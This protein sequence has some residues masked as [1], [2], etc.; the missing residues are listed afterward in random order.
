LQPL[1]EPTQTYNL[2][3][4][5]DTHTFFANGKVVHNSFNK[6]S[7]GVG[8]DAGLSCPAGQE[9]IPE[10]GGACGV[11][12]KNV[13]TCPSGQSRVNGVCVETKYEAAAENCVDRCG[14]DAACKSNCNAKYSVTA[15]SAQGSLTDAQYRQ[16]T[17]SCVH[18]I[19]ISANRCLPAPG[20]TNGTL[21]L[22]TG[23]GCSVSSQCDSGICSNAGSCVATQA[24]ATAQGGVKPAGNANELYKPSGDIIYTGYGADVTLKDPTITNKSGSCTDNYDCALGYS[25]GGGSCKKDSEMYTCTSNTG[26]P[27]GYSCTDGVCGANLGKTGG[28]LDGTCSQATGGCPAG[29]S[30]TDTGRCQSER[31]N[32]PSGQNPGDG[33]FGLCKGVVCTNAPGGCIAIHM[34]PEKW[35]DGQVTVTYPIVTT[36]SVDAQ[37]IAN[38]NCMHV[39][40]DV[41]NG[42]SGSCAKG[43]PGYGHINGD[44]STLVGAVVVSP[45]NCTP[46]PTQVAK[47]TQTSITS[48]DGYTPPTGG[49]PT[50]GGSTPT[51]TPTVRPSTSPTATPSG[52]PVATATPTPTPTTTTTG[53]TPTPTPTITQT[54]A[55]VGC[56]DACTQTSD[57]S[58]LNHICYQGACRLAS[59]PA[60]TSCVLPAA[61]SATQP[62]AGQPSLPQELPTSGSDT[63]GSIMKVGLG[64]LSFGALLLL[65]L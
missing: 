30:C 56:G 50:G 42:G 48:T 35:P 51:P 26:C 46:T 49:T 9:P 33:S 18:G 38:E 15:P 24:E 63:L 64:V 40:V 45:T 36:G 53:A 12:T 58:N 23:S 13:T 37:K 3:T 62:Q 39:Q 22:G 32:P 65:F 25:C 19:D 21:N 5:Q 11:P 10:A 4:V 47:T 20:T 8:N 61:G 41:L 27:A 14:S 6:Q 55:L 16:L 34:L 2:A 1:L 57:C 7:A 52:T 59:N 29:F 44:W 17:Q 54:A 43:S 28:N 60:S 31:S